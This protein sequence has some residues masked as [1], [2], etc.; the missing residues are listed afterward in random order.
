MSDK[1]TI[2][3]IGATGAQGG[4][5]VRAILA[6]PE[7]RAEMGRRN[8]EKAERMFTVEATVDR[9]VQLYDRLTGAL[10]SNR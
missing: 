5:L 1:K 4:G 2:A 6:D 7:R 10:P 9:Y 8:R 3:V